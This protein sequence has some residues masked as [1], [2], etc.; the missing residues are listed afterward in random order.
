MLFGGVD[1]NEEAHENIYSLNPMICPRLPSPT[2]RTRPRG[3]ASP[4][5][6]LGGAS[7]VPEVLRLKGVATQACI[8]CAPGTRTLTAGSNARNATVDGTPPSFADAGAGDAD[9]TR[10]AAT[11]RTQCVVC[12]AG[13]L[14]T[15]PGATECAACP[16]GTYASSAGSATWSACQLCPAGTFANHSG[17]SACVPCASVSEEGGDAIAEQEMACP[18]G[19]PISQMSSITR[20]ELS[21]RLSLTNYPDAQ[22]LDRARGADLLTQQLRL[23]VIGIIAYFSFLAILTATALV[24]AQSPFRPTTPWLL[25]LSSSLCRGCSLV[26]GFATACVRAHPLTALPPA[27][28]QVSPKAAEDLLRC[29]DVPPISGGV[30]NSKPGGFFTI[31]FLFVYRCRRGLA[32]LLRHFDVLTPRGVCGV[33]VCVCITSFFFVSLAYQYLFWNEQVCP[34]VCAAVGGGIHII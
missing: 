3:I 15:S 26:S 13:W 18:I 19:S 27:T 8:D 30:G 29:M 5:G 14:S 32:P 10:A 21:E 31:T 12:P 33:N 9:G 23:L 17:S 11:L 22:Q 20:R 4:G 25:F 16:P 6:G 2:A 7:E 24:R 34:H 1:A 28:L